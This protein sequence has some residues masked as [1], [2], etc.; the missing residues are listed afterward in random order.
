MY[1]GAPVFAYLAVKSLIFG[2]GGRHRTGIDGFA[3]RCMQI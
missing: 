2:G 1:V 3:G